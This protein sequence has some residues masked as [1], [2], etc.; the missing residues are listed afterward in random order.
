LPSPIMPSVLM[1]LLS[2]SALVLGVLPALPGSAPD[3]AGQAV[4]RGRV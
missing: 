1:S 4:V 3:S 2:S